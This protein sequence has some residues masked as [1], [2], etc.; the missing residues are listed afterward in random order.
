M[1]EYKN[2]GTDKVFRKIEI[3]WIISMPIM[4]YQILFKIKT[5]NKLTFFIIMEWRGKS[6]DIKILLNFSLDKLDITEIL[7][8]IEILK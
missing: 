4:K 2:Q 1:L 6:E 8:Y 3:C 7:K 5:F